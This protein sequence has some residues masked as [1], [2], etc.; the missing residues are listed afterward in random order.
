[1]YIKFVNNQFT[2]CG[3]GAIKLQILVIVTGV[4]SRL[5]LKGKGKGKWIFMWL[6]LK[7]FRYG[8]VNVNVNL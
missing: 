2:F 7:T 5:I 1:M 6:T 4:V 3:N 8:N